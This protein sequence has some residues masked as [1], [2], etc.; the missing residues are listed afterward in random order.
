MKV[1]LAFALAALAALWLHADPVDLRAKFIERYGARFAG[2]SAV[3]ADL[4]PDT[5][6]FERAR[7]SA[8]WHL[9]L[10]VEDD[11]RPCFIEATISGG[12]FMKG[13]LHVFGCADERISP[14]RFK[15]LRARVPVLA[16]RSGS[17]RVRKFGGKELPPPVAVYPPTSRP[18]VRLAPRHAESLAFDPVARVLGRFAGALPKMKVSLSELKYELLLVGPKDMKVSL[19]TGAAGAPIAQAS[20]A[21]AIRTAIETRSPELKGKVSDRD[22]VDF[23]VNSKVIQKGVP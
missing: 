17:A 10:P 23:Y 16:V 21:G 2:G 20:A 9:A 22:V 14:A 13:V 19:G 5:A 3:A 18:C 8:V 4:L 12:R 11:D 1:S 6:D 15:E 7:G